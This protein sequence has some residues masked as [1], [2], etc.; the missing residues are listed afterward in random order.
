MQLPGDKLIPKPGDKYILW[1]LRM[2]DE[3][4]S[5]AEEEL[6]TA[7]NAFNSE[8]TLDIAVFK[9]PTDHEWIE[10]N[11]VRLSIGQRVRLESDKYFPGTGYRDSRITGIT[12][13]VNL[14]S[15]MDLEISDALS[16]SAMQKVSDSIG[17]QKICPVHSRLHFSS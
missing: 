17:D 10:E 1:N 6:L 15:C 9:A 4:Y 12:R 2:P 5:L 14:P 8:H 7:V 13:K 16:R 11:A 3:Y